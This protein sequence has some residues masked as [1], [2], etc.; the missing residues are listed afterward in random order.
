MSKVVLNDVTAGFASA[1][2]VN[3]NSE[4]IE[5]A[6]ENTLSRDGSAPNHM[7]A[8]IDMN[9]HMIL[10]LGNPITVSGVNWE[11]PWV[12]GTVYDIGDIIESGGSAYIAILAHTS[13][14]FATDLSSGKWQ[15][16]ATASLPSQTG[17]SG[18]YLNTDGSTAS[19][20]AISKMISLGDPS[21][22]AVG[23]GITDDT[24]AIQAAVDAAAGKAL[25][26]P[27][28]TSAYYLASNVTKPA[29]G[30][31]VVTD[32]GVTFTGT[33]RMFQSYANNYHDYNGTFFARNISGAETAGRG[34][35]SLSA[36]FTA[37]A[38]F[39]GNG[40]AAFFSTETPA[41]AQ[42][43]YWALNPILE[44]NPGLT[45]NGVC[46]EVDL[47]NFASDGKGQALLITGVGSAKPQVGIALQ[48]GDT[49]SDW[50]YGQWIKNSQIGMRVDG[51]NVTAPE[52]GIEVHNYPKNLLKLKP[53]ND[54]NPTDAA[55]FL[56]NAG[57]SQVNWKLTKQGG[58][59][60]GNGSTEVTKHYSTT[61]TLNFGSVSAHSS[62]E[63]TITVTGA[64]VG[65]VCY[66]SPNLALVS[67]FTWSVYCA[68]A[69]TITVR[70]LNG[71]A[72]ALDP[73]GAGGATWRVDVWKH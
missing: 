24:A 38:G 69:N 26:I 72:G 56:A 5:V 13:G 45:G 55:M 9:G 21:F 61:A 58:M 41:N 59:V 65:D 12:T 1:A 4:V 35:S 30:I 27:K 28:P 3:A 11:G 49:T 15:I 70:V 29:S 8:N 68:A 57:D 7:N 34:Y 10:N 64:A 47:D 19:W 16:F 39:L 31:T 6:F 60:I 52:F 36:D 42:G 44:L 50:Q 43:F 67:G 71:T 25:F 54:T 66:G 48:R 62:A 17:S 18:K 46:T 32:C 73:D 20:A 14:T 53:L 63:L 37:A 33:G 40:C 23:D 51:A 22:S 2:A